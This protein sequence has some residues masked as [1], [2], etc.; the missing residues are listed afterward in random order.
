MFA[1]STRN[2]L[3]RSRL[4][5]LVS[6]RRRAPKQGACLRAATTLAA[7]AAAVRFGDPDNCA[8]VEASRAASCVSHRKFG[9]KTA[10][11]RLLN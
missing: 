1:A 9:R 5:V 2:A 10:S 6:T 11:P 7:T 4:V 8:A 3:P